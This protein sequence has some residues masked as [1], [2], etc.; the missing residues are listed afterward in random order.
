MLARWGHCS[1]RDMGAWSKKRAKPT[2]LAQGHKEWKKK[3]IKEELKMQK[4][5]LQKEKLKAI[6]IH[7]EFF[8][9]T[10]KK[11]LFFWLS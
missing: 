5:N 10:L 3:M 8:L 9:N 1:H 4:I 6:R 7:N 11:T 2:K